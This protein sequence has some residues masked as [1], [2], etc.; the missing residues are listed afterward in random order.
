M[1]KRMVSLVL[2]LIL[3]VT[4][5]A[6]VN[7]QNIEK[8]DEVE[9]LET[10][11]NNLV[12]GNIEEAFADTQDE[13]YVLSSDITIS[14][15]SLEEQ[16]YIEY[17]ENGDYFADEYA[18]DP[19]KSY[20]ILEEL[21]NNIITVSI[22]FEDGS[23]AIVPFNIIEDE[24]GFKVKITE[25]DL[26]DIGYIEL[27]TVVE[28]SDTSISTYATSLD[29]YE[30]SY[31][32]G[33]IYGIDEFSVTKNAITIS[34][35]QENYMLSAGWDADAEVIYAVVKERWYGD[36]VWATTT[37][38]I[39]GNKSF[40]ITIVGKNSEQSD[41]KIRISNQTGSNPR[42]QGYGTLYSVTA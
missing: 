9:F 16:S 34:G 41:L 17:V 40:S 11:L 12:S 25:Q 26:S 38:A 29:T 42:S 28:I 2:M 20:E 4:A 3:A 10:Y 39:V 5:V 24:D 32:Y 37:G 19:I 18:E 21:D 14:A 27:S 33:T 8:S 30:F 1:K 23:E 13:R 36:Y 31:L 35:Y 22:V 6:S 15:L 7:A